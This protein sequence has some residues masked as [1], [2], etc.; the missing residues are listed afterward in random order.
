M[1][2]WE[3]TIARNR[4]DPSPVVVLSMPVK[5]IQDRDF[6]RVL[7]EDLDAS[8]SKWEQYTAQEGGH[9]LA[10]DK[11]GLYMFVW[12]PSS[13][14]LKTDTSPLKFRIP[15]YIGRTEVS[16]KERYRS[17][18]NNLIRG[19]EA[20]LFWSTAEQSC[21]GTRLRKYFSLE[22]LEYWCCVVVRPELL[23]SLETRLLSLFNPP[24]NKQRTLRAVVSQEKIWRL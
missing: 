6:S 17:E 14:V 23:R 8:C 21:R 1:L 11:P 24:A 16:L 4:T 5:Y 9:S 10:P 7:H 12:T 22:P 2:A 20:D 3:K 18:Y 13:L 15:I 19:A